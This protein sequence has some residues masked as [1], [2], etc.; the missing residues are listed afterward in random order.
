MAPP[1]MPLPIHYYKLGDLL[2][3]VKRGQRYAA[4]SVADIRSGISTFHLQAKTPEVAGKPA[5]GTK[6]TDAPKAGAHLQVLS[7]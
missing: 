2:D 7:V 5:P 1:D 6:R 3:S 4:V